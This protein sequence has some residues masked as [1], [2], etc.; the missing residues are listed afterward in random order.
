VSE[1]S[2][3]S[4]DP[5]CYLLTDEPDINNI[6]YMDIIKYLKDLFLST[7]SMLQQ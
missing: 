5:E 4:D 2:E 1:S 3:L 7:D 6:S